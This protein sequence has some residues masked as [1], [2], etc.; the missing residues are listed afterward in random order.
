MGSEDRVGDWMQTASGGQF[1]P[2]DPRAEEVLIWDI[3]HALSNQCRFAGHCRT[4]YSVAEHSVRVSLI[5][6]EGEMLAA[7][8]HDAVEAYLVDLPRPVKRSPGIGPRYVEAE[9][10]V[11]A[12]IEA[13]F[14]LA[15]GATSSPAIKA[16]DNCLLMTEARDLMARPPATWKESGSRPLE[17]EIVPWWPRD[18][19]EEFL[20]RFSDLTRV[21]FDE[22][23][24]RV[25]EIDA[26]LP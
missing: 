10:K 9:A 12:A 8:L 15:P 19:R 5:V 17:Q 21:S 24:S 4:F 23:A 6:P 11:A 26:V 22:L 7:L 3:A 20:R 14:D 25:A 16:A 2:I 13:R 18:A 1:W